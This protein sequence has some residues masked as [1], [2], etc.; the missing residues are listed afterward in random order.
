MKKFILCLAIMALQIICIAQPTVYKVTTNQITY[1][2]N[3]IN[4]GDKNM[5][6]YW[7]TLGGLN[8]GLATIDSSGNIVNNQTYGHPTTE[9]PLFARR[10]TNNE[11]MMFGRTYYY[12][13][14]HYRAQVIITDTLG[15]FKREIAFKPDSI[16]FNQLYNGVY[17][18]GYY[19]F[20]GEHYDPLLGYAELFVSKTDTLGTLIWY[21]KNFTQLSSTNWPRSGLEI[22]YDNKSL[23]FGTIY[24]DSFQ[25]V[26]PYKVYYSYLLDQIDTNGN[27]IQRI[28]LPIRPDIF[29]TNSSNRILSIEKINGNRY[30]VVGDKDLFFLDTAFHVVQNDTIWQDKLIGRFG[31]KH[32]TEESYIM[33]GGNEIAKYY[34]GDTIFIKDLSD[35]PNF[36]AVH[37]VIP[38]LDGGYFAVIHQHYKTTYIKMDCEG[39]YINPT[40]CVP[41]YTTSYH[42]MAIDITL[43]ADIGRWIL[44]CKGETKKE[45][46][47]V[48]YNNQGQIL[49]QNK[50]TKGSYKYDIDNSN[51]AD[52]LYFIKLY[53][54]DGEMIL[55]GVK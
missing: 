44:T 19:Y 10:N 9:I 40:W 43:Y 24:Q 33:G 7:N 17:L 21:T 16:E 18:N 34:H 6:F 50:I 4:I 35:I 22:T 46:Q 55:K 12:D 3:I 15:N 29:Q 49:W 26:S 32:L 11:I 54:E 51:Y 36:V 38:Q 2:M 8:Y 45:L 53:N 37:D 30:F 28:P 5:I 48:V 47:V 14:S 39:N 20:L 52:G 41:L 31:Y 42:N 23:L 27:F 25:V 13:T 1:S